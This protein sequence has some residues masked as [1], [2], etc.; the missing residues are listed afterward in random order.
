MIAGSRES[1]AANP[2]PHG[3]RTMTMRL[4]L[5]DGIGVA[6]YYAAGLTRLKGAVFAAV[7]D[8]DAEAALRSGNAIGA[9][10]ASASLADLL[11]HEPD[12]FDAVVLHGSDAARAGQAIAAARAGKHVLAETPMAL[13]VDDADAVIRA[14]RAAGVCLMVGQAMRFMAAQRTV[15]DAVVSGKLGVPGLLRI[16]HWEA[17]SGSTARS[18]AP[19]GKSD[20]AR[21]AETLVARIIR[22]LDLAVWL[23]DER[24][25][26]I[27]G[28]GRHQT[29]G[30]VPDY[31]QLHLGFPRGGMALVDRFDALPVDSTP[32]FSLTLIGS[33][34][35][36]YADD[37]HN[38]NLLYRE[39]S[40]T[41]LL[42]GQGD[43]HMA[44]QLQTFVDGVRQ[45]QEVPMEGAQGRLAV[46]IADAAVKSL[47][48]RQPAHLVGGRYEVI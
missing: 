27:Y 42:A 46:E 21:L 15:K 1:V 35:A 4:A 19:T 45:Q 26:S 44:A 9:G 16:H 17:S 38:M 3:G 6:R 37:H 30:A 2:W 39:G 36:A 40:P 23:F 20:D 48:A 7:V 43:S 41:A 29:G 8:P 33:T 18:P 34:G 47:A 13:S 11:E 28:L 14:C 22:E 31:V 10:I 12:S 24:P 32:Y 5:V 25:T